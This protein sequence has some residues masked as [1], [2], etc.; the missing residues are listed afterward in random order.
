[1]LMYSHSNPMI[2]PGRCEHASVG[3]VPSNSVDAP[4]FV[5]TKSFDQLAVLLVPDVYLRVCSHISILL[6]ST[7]ITTD[8]DCR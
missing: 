7:F 3:R 1:M 5:A 4:P 2:V 8:L 6:K